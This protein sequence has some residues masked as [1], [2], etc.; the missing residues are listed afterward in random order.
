MEVNIF[1]LS[2]HVMKEPTEEDFVRFIN[3]AE[4]ID[5]SQVRNLESAQESSKEFIKKFYNWSRRVSEHL[6][7][8]WMLFALE[9]QELRL[10]PFIG[11]STKEEDAFIGNFVKMS[12]HPRLMVRE[13]NW[14]PVRLRCWLAK[15]DRFRKMWDQIVISVK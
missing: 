13:Y 9:E 10:V 12:G 6:S 3:W 4:I 15:P 2:F 7:K 1:E 5:F 14:K 11:Y 8:R